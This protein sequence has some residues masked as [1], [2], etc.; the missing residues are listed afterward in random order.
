M[1]APPIEV[2]DILNDSA[3]AFFEARGG[4]VSSA[5]RRVV[6]DLISCRTA[7]L[8]GH[9][10]RC[11]SCG[12]ERNAYNSCRNRHCPKCQATACAKWLDAR[13]DDLLPVEYFHVV[14]TVPPE[15]AAIAL[16]NK[17]V[18]YDILFRAAGD[19]LLEVAADPNHLGAHIGFLAVLHT[20]TQTLLHHPHVHCVVPGGGL[21]EDGTEWISCKRGFFLPV[22]V[23]GRVFRGKFLEQTRHA[24]VQGRL[25]FQG[26]LSDLREPDR[27]R[28]YLDRSCAHDWVVYAK[29]PFGGP[30]PVL[31]YLAQYTHRVA[32][33]NRRLISFRDGR[34][35]FRYRDSADSSRQKIM[36][37]SAIEFTRRFLLHV[38]PRG[39]VRIRHF[40]LLANTH[41]RDKVALCRELIGG[42]D[43][44]DL[45]A[46]SARQI[47]Q[48]AQ[49]TDA[50][51]VC[52]ACETGI[53][54]P[55]LILARSPLRAGP[56]LQ[57]QPIDSS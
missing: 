29:R 12:H 52:P 22:K 27:F 26:S 5:K 34:V 42:P 3:R 25:S 18:M 39:F 14:F 32:I 6:R 31:K 54:V 11:D 2:A 46:D 35:R 28:E 1:G 15:I 19:T 57:P 49:D 45:L 44:H 36:E 47:E 30:A 13:G 56:W 41:R 20:W 37:L 7:A 53:M 23:L 9:V 24:F 16:Q 4:T 10:E 38:L 48:A 33:S 50:H 43:Q 8:G 51:R 21:S 17:K 40:G 55:I